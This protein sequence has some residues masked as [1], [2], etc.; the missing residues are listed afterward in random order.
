M[1]GLG[2]WQ[3]RRAEWKGAMIARYS[4]A[5]TLSPVAWPRNAAEREDA[6]YRPS[7]V[8]CAA[9]LA[10]RETAG[11]S[12]AGQSGWS[13]VARCRLADGGE[14]EVAL[15]WSAAPSPPTWPGG[16]VTGVVAPA[17]E[18]VRLVAAP[19]QAGLQPLARP[20]PRDLPNNHLAYAGQW[21]FFAVTALIIYG[22]A[23]RSRWA[24]RPGLPPR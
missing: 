13:H 9:V 10:L 15:G 6:L 4:A 5:Q 14:A 22:L 1:V 16:T 17:G 18:S 8:N 21:F 20:D 2:I 19:A 3:L 23:L 7:S 24:G 12:A 11:R